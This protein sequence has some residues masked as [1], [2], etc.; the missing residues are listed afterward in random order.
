[1]TEMDGSMGVRWEDRKGG[2]VGRWVCDN[3]T[4]GPGGEGLCVLYGKFKWGGAGGHLARMGWREGGR[5]YRGSG[6]SDV[7]GN[8]PWGQDGASGYKTILGSLIELQL[9]CAPLDRA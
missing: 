1:M 9:T 3:E 7:G 2:R 4:T 8:V 5:C 6:L